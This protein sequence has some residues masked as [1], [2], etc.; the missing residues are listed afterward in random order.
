MSELP[1]SADMQTRL[2]PCNNRL[3]NHS[4]TCK[5]VDRS[6]ASGTYLHFRKIRRSHYIPVP[7]GIAFHLDQTCT[8]SR[9]HLLAR[10]T[11]PSKRTVESNSRPRPPS[12]CSAD[13]DTP[14]NNDRSESSRVS[15]T[16]RYHCSVDDWHTYRPSVICIHTLFPSNPVGNGRKTV[17]SRSDASY[18]STDQSKV[19]RNR[20]GSIFSRIFAR[21]TCPCRR[22]HN[23]L[24]N[25][26]RTYRYL[27]RRKDSMCTG[28][29][30]CC[31]ARPRCTEYRED[32]PKI[33][34]DRCSL[35][36]L[37][38]ISSSQ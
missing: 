7:V 12:R 5:R 23:R 6:V 15:N 31:N 1:C 24:S 32:I 9:I 16:C 27:L 20:N 33:Q 22:R 37:H 21:C 29:R 13:R 25:H 14:T 34:R 36:R 10:Y 19:C 4:G 38:C 11:A 17:P 3:R 26:A 8:H 35:R 28:P 30:K 18:K 2:E